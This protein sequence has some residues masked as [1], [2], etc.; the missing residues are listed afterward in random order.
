MV[1]VCC[2]FLL[3]IDKTKPG[4]GLSLFLVLGSGH[5]VPCFGVEFMVHICVGFQFGCGAML[6]FMEFMAFLFICGMWCVLLDGI[7][8]IL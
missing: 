3:H 6:H 2:C 8:V 1:Y 7:L 4:L 5:C